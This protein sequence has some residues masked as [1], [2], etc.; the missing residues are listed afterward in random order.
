MVDVG[1]DNEGISPLLFHCFGYDAVSFIDDPMTDG[2]D[3][4]G[5]EQA[6]VVSN[7][8]FRDALIQ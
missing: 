2:F 5:F 6:N 7:A 3:S 1:L 8:D 4:L